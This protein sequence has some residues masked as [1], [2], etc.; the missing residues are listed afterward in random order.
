MTN[1]K[2]RKYD[3][4]NNRFQGTPYRG[5]PRSGAPEAGRHAVRQPTC[6]KGHK[7]GSENVHS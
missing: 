7:G 4:R 6:P 3:A 2:Y 5:V 1:A